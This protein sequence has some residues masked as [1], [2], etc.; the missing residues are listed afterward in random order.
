[1]ILAVD[2]GDPDRKFR[3]FASGF[4][5]AEPCSD[6]DD[7]RYRRVHGLSGATAHERLASEPRLDSLM[8]QKS[9][10]FSSCDS[11]ELPVKHRHTRPHSSSPYIRTFVEICVVFTL[12]L[13]AVWIPQGRAN[14][15]LN[16]SAAAC[17][18]AFAVASRW[19]ARELG[20]TRPFAGIISILLAGALLCGAIVVIGVPLRFAGAGKSLPLGRSWQ[21]VLWALAQ[22]FILQSIFFVR[23]ESLLGSRRA[24]LAAAGLFAIAHMPSPLLTVLS[25]FGGVFFCE[26]FRRFRNLYVLGILHGALGLTISASLPDRWLHHMRVGIG[27]LRFP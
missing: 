21:Y 24:V 20:L 4:Q 6:N 7:T 5:S 19:S 1:M 17:V 2:D 26:L 15:L 3:Q 22:E 11:S 12:I 18:V 9:E 13:S 25:F 23:L 14:A 27:Y 10:V 8:L 16:I